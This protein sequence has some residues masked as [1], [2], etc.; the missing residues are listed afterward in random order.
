M[1]GSSGENGNILIQ[2]LKENAMNKNILQSTHNW[3]KVWKSLAAQKADDESIEWYKPKTLNVILDQFTPKVCK[4]DGDD[5]QPDNLHVMVL[6]S[7]RN[8]TNT[9]SFVTENLKFQSKLLRE[10][11]GYCDNKA[12]ANGR[13]MQEV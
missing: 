11:P 1:A 6:L 13:A 2:S 10:K 3:I 12:K 4:K 7:Q 8:H 5:Y 9:S